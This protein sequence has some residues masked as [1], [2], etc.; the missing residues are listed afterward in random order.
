MEHFNLHLNINELDDGSKWMLREQL[1]SPSYACSGTNIKYSRGWWQYS[2]GEEDRVCD[3]WVGESF[4]GFW[5]SQQSWKLCIHSYILEVFPLKQLFDLPSDV[6]RYT[7][8]WRIIS[9]CLILLTSL[10]HGVLQCIKCTGPLS[11]LPHVTHLI[12]VRSVL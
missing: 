6:Y 4:L 7:L 2:W 11:D 9:S 10:K 12:R 5:L 8:Y 3:L 1:G